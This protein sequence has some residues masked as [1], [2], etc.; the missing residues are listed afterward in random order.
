MLELDVQLDFCKFALMI[1]EITRM[2]SLV[3]DH[4]YFAL[5]DPTIGALS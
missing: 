3:V 5:N 4:I 2:I 1:A